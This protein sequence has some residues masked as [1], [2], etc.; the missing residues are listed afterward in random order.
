MGIR[1]AGIE[2][3][4]LQDEHVKKIIPA[5][6][7]HVPDIDC[8]LF[9]NPPFAE[10]CFGILRRFLYCRYIVDDFKD[11]ENERKPWLQEKYSLHGR[12]FWDY[13]VLGNALKRGNFAQINN[14]NTSI[15]RFIEDD[16]AGLHKDKLRTL[17]M[18]LENE[19]LSLQMYDAMSSDT[20]LSY[21]SRLKRRVFSLVNFIARQSSVDVLVRK[22]S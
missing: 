3:V 1:L 22:V 14:G 19:S 20:K 7:W 18:M 10:C 17:S 21:V 16:Y 6:Q 12:E 2:E 15:I 8:S 5:E 13:A 9:S 4:L 11:H